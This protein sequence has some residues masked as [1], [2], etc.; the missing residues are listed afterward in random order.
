MNAASDGAGFA[1][2]R[3]AAL[4]VDAE[5]LIVGST[6]GTHIGA[7][8]ARAATR[9][10]M[11]WI[12]FD[13]IEASRGPRVLQSIAW[14]LARRPLW[15]NRFGDQVV[16]HS[17]N[18]AS[19]TRVLVA[20]GAV[21]LTAAAILQL[22]TAKVFCINY[23]TDDPWNRNHRADWQLRALK[24]Y[25]VV[26][27]PR[28][29]NIQDFRDLGCSDVRYLPFAYDDELFSPPEASS[30]TVPSHDVLFVGGGDRDRAAFL[31]RFKRDGLC[32]A[33]IGGYWSRFPET[34]GCDLGHKD[35]GEL[36]A[37]TAAA[38]VNLCLVRR[39]NRDGNVM[40]SFEIPAVG[41]FMLAED[42]PEHHEI[43]GAEGDKVLYFMT[44]ETAA[45]KA[46][47]ALANPHERRR[48]A[49]AARQL[50]SKGRHTY[51]DRLLQ[52]LEVASG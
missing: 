46:R 45:E 33:L 14:H 25:D 31:A 42:T 51:R 6:G 36:R 29:A 18:R 39:A 43:F 35:A 47:W 44:P 34:R 24:H 15:L 40:R 30:T 13:T 27:T 26:F 41:G 4:G 50:I 16:A 17:R 38:A 32:P 5:L 20:T 19:K 52:M 10:G 37:L 22:K 21:P 28:R 7:S 8:F 11:Q 12:L 49:S 23:S 48:M 3:P 2:D 9:L 1:E